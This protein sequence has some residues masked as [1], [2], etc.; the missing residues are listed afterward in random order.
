MDSKLVVWEKEGGN[1]GVK[2]KRHKTIRHKISYKDVLYNRKNIPI[3]Y[4]STWSIIFKSV[5]H[6]IAYL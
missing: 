3:Y 1:I 2:K 6:Y 4:N 5:S